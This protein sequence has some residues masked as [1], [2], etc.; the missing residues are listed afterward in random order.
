[1]G[2]RL[3]G[4]GGA[5]SVSYARLPFLY[6]NLF[7]FSVSASMDLAACSR[8]DPLSSY[9]DLATHCAYI[10]FVGVL[11]LPQIVYLDTEGGKSLSV[12]HP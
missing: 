5:H 7:Y 8:D 9:S 12:I 1:M 4:Q 2:E 11:C 3:H 10:L 6:E